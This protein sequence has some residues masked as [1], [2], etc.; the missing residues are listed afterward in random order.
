VIIWINGAFGA[1]KTTLAGELRRRLPDAMEFDPEYVG[2]ILV[3]WVPQPASGDFQDIPLWRKLVADFAVGL[4]SEYRRPLIVPMT[5]VNPRYR[6]EIFG[7][8]ETAGER[9][10]HVFLD[11]PAAELRRR[12]DA[13]VLVPGDPVRDHE[14]RAFRQ[15]NVER[16]LAARAGLPDST[17]VLSSAEHSPD[18]LA[19]L[20]LD[21]L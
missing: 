2:A 11:L 6:D 17:L 21:A 10:L 5:L 19:E 13:Q 20:V 18:R 12:I 7:P 16:C 3:K 14:S 1:G 9:L 4:A 8:I 15:R